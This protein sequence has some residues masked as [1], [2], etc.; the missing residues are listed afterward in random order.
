MG[1]REKGGGE[2]E[3][4]IE[5]RER[6]RRV[7]GERERRV[8]GRG[9]GIERKIERERGRWMEIPGRWRGMN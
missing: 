6:E 8:G 3:G 1:E 9:G 5:W 2:R 7:G 4:G